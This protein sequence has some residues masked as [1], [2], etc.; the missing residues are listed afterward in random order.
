MTGDDMGTPSD[1]RQLIC[2]V[3]NDNEKKVKQN[4]L[5]PRV[6]FRIRKWGASP[7]TELFLLLWD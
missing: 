1:R 3:K 4:E 7:F 2:N 5:T 6:S